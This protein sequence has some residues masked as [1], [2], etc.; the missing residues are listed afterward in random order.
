MHGVPAEVLSDRGP[1]FLSGLIAEVDML[2]GFLKVNTT[3]YQPQTDGL[4]EHFN[5]TLIATLAKTVQ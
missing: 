1:A 3:V 2:L 5:R 4:V